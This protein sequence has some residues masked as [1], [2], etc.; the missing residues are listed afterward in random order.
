MKCIITMRININKFMNDNLK[1]CEDYIANFPKNSVFPTNL[2]Q[3]ELEV[4]QRKHDNEDYDISPNEP[5]HWPYLLIAERYV[6]KHKSNSGGRRP[7]KK[8]SA[9][10]RR[11]SNA[12]K[13]RSTRR[14]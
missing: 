8:R 9:R 3:F 12:R 10:R 2:T 14:K 6:Q 4:K 5:D 7:S 1:F 11:S 13:S